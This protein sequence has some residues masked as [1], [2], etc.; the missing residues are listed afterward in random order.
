VADPA[1][2]NFGRLKDLSS[3]E[4]RKETNTNWELGIPGLLLSQ[5]LIESIG[6]QFELWLFV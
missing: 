2:T 1:S 3:L 4:V 6:P 5:S